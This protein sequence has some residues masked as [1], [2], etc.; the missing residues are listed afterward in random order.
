[1]QNRETMPQKPAPT[2]TCP[3][4]AI[5]PVCCA[6]GSPL[7]TFQHS[8]WLYSHEPP[9]MAQNWSPPLLHQQAKLLTSVQVPGDILKIPKLPLD[10]G[11]VSSIS[12]KEMTLSSHAHPSFP[13]WTHEPGPPTSF[14]NNTFNFY[15]WQ[16]FCSSKNKNNLHDP[17]HKCQPLLL[18]ASVPTCPLAFEGGPHVRVHL[19]DAIPRETGVQS[20]VK[21]HANVL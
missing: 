15:H 8:I 16:N 6:L 9:K 7:Q 5:H 21:V 20:H 17:R 19:Y 11:Q 12:S 2:Y 13:W 1:M 4:P 14:L 3:N 10:I 18:K